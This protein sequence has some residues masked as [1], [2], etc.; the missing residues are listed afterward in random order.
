MRAYLEGDRWGNFIVTGSST[1]FAKEVSF[2]L[3]QRPVKVMAVII[4]R[5]KVGKA[6]L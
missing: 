6:L 4:F 5:F 1:G 2:A 3:P